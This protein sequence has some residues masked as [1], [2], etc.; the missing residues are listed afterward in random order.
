M[1]DYTHRE[2]EILLSA[3]RI[4][5][6]TPRLA[7]VL[8]AA[9][10]QT[11][12][13]A[14]AYRVY[15]SRLIQEVLFQFLKCPHPRTRIY[16]GRQKRG[17][18]DEFVPPFL[19][20]G[21]DLRS[22]AR[23]ISGALDLQALSGIYNPLIIQESI[24]CKAR[25]Q[26]VFVNYEC[27]GIIKRA[28]SRDLRALDTPESSAAPPLEDAEVPESSSAEIV[29]LIGGLLRSV[30]LN[31]IAVEIAI[32]GRGWLITEFVRPP[33]LWPSPEG[34]VNRHRHICRL[35]ESNKL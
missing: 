32:S 1:G 10:K 23:L 2:R 15:K 26:L 21:P 27:A 18:A 11:F 19:A 33:L 17:I 34:M 28:T 24:E 7:A 14:F 6:P 29:P 13:S 8:E 20:M 25:F 5:F 9:G 3:N 12:P 22:G 31:D 16:Y 35:V 30:R 4:F